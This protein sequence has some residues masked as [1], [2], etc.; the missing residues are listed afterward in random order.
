MNN[1]FPI[2]E[3][4][5]NHD[6]DERLEDEPLIPLGIGD[7]VVL[8]MK[9]FKMLNE[10]YKRRNSANNKIPLNTDY[11][12]DKGPLTDADFIHTDTLTDNAG[13]EIFPI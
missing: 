1:P 10:F 6:Y 13:N 4:E 8:S 12:F 5:E 3:I 7:N 11:N 2:R 9:L